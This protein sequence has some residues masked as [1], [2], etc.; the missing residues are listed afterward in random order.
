MKTIKPICIILLVILLTSFKI[1]AQQSTINIDQLSN[2]QLMQYLG[3]ANASGL[4]E[5]E[6]EAKARQ[7]GLSEDQIQK[8]RIRIGAANGGASGVKGSNTDITESRT[9]AS[10]KKSVESPSTDE[11]KVF[12]SDLF[13]RENL[14]FEPNLQIPTPRNYMIGV[15]DQ[16]NIDLFGYSDVNY[17]LKVSPEGTIR[18]P[19]FGPVKVMG[20]S[21]E[22]A[23]IKIKAAL[24]QIYPQIAEG[25]T[26]V[27]LSVGQM[28][29]IKV[30]LIGEI[31]KPG[32]YTLP[33]L[34][35]I[36]NAL[37]VS[38]G[39]NSIGSYRNIE[40]VRNGKTI[41]HFDLYDFLLK[42][43]LTKNLRLEEEDII[44]VNPYETRV[45]ISGAIKRRAI[46][47]ITK[48]EVLSDLLKLA[49]GYTDG[50][51]QEFIRVVRYGKNEREIL[52]VTVANLN[53]FILKSGDFCLVDSVANKFSNRVIIG[54]AVFHP[55]NYSLKD[56]S[57]L[58]SLLAVA[59]LKSEAFLKR[60]VITRR[61]DNY[62]LRSIDFNV[63]DIVHGNSS[64]IL[65]NE[66]SVRIFSIFD[67][68]HRDS[69]SINGEVYKQG[70][71][72]YTDSMQLQD[73][74]L[75]A[76]G[77]TE[78]ASAKRIEISRRICDTSTENESNNY[79]IVSV[80]DLHKDLSEKE[81]SAK[82][83]LKPFD[84]VSIR[85]NPAY[86]EQIKVRIEGEVLYPGDYTVEKKTETL[87]DLIAKAGGLRANAYSEGAML[88]RNTFSDSIEASLS[89]DRLESARNQS[90]KSD[91]LTQILTNS[92]TKTRKIVGIKLERS[93]ETPHGKEDISLLEGD[94]LK[95]PPYP[96]TVQSF[97]AVYV[98]KK[99]VYRNNLSFK[100]VIEES[101]GFLTT[102]SRKKAYIMYPNGEIK[103]TS[104]FFWFKSYPKVKPGA[105]IYVPLFVRKT[106][107]AE[108]ASIGVAAASVASLL[109]SMIYL[110]RSL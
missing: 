4:T 66:D 109:I 52:T 44:K 102:A 107:T 16:L 1:Y 32:S 26:A 67:I 74:I 73:L 110:V 24:T 23:Q 92:I 2:E 30:T 56:F 7:K 18:I 94:L 64:L 72:P 21:F 85:K 86:R 59:N 8:L 55:G 48:G 49:G 6:L 90:I 80:I 61:G 83:V 41:V 98:P 105:E 95:I 97:G 34:A 28:R 69:V 12:G 108:I 43:D 78:G 14:T 54:G 38:G 68:K 51:Y 84:I 15:G 96:T 63:D 57:N 40:L 13:S 22:D 65:Q 88:I 50:A 76:G 58:Q 89:E 104:H 25:K 53:N 39:P 46:Y 81:S 9:I 20:L 62:L 82:F 106:T 87:S 79:S 36:A 91:S 101:G 45:T 37:Y 77:F 17:K 27:Q 19:N 10:I 5:S 29:S 47:E 70:F 103:T 3:A 93:L 35:S 42:G 60:G 71:F 33:S 31:A 75:Q 11:I 100:D 99:I